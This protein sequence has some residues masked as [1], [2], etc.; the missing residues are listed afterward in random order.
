[1]Y[2]IDS[3]NKGSVIDGLIGRLDEKMRKSLIFHRSITF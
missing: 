2:C 3:P 1:M